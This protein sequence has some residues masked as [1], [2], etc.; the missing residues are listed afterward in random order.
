MGD[1]HDDVARRIVDETRMLV[2]EAMRGPRPRAPLFLFGT[3]PA[4]ALVLW[5]V[6]DAVRKIDDGDPVARERFPRMMQAFVKVVMAVVED[7]VPF[8]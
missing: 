8:R 2:R 1:E 5:E 7:E 3:I 6:M 4:R